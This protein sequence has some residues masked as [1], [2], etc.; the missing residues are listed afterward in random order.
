MRQTG[1][2]E[3]RGDSTDLAVHDVLM[4]RR[5][6]IDQEGWSLEHDDKHSSGDLSA[7]AG[8]YALFSALHPDAGQPPEQW[9]WSRKWWKPKEHRRNLV[10]AAAMLI[11]EIERIDRSRI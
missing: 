3:L 2:E 5:R 7:A 10:R 6:Q 8:C 9:P 4:E 1:V 11:A